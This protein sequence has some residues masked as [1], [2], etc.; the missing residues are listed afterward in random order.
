MAKAYLLT[1]SNLG[2]R[3][4]LLEEARERLSVLAG[5]IGK[6]SSFYESP[7]WGYKSKSVFMNQALEINTMLSPQELLDTCLKIEEGLGRSRGYTREYA[8]RPIDIDIL[9]Y[10]DLIIHE[11]RLS[12][13]HPRLEQRRFVLVPLAEIAPDIVHPVHLTTVSELLESC[14]D[15]AEVVRSETKIVS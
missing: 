15:P 12:I 5:D 13:P 4:M 8:D 10:D 3:I 2:D 6:L 1:G 11:P 7:P 14:T 9:F